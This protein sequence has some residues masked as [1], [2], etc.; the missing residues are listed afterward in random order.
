[1][2]N[3]VRIAGC[4]IL[5]SISVAGLVT[6]C[7][8]GS[9]KASA[10]TTITVEGLPATTKPGPRKAFLADV[11]AFE[12]ANPT[13]VVKPTD[14]AWDSQTFAAKLAGKT[15]ETV[16]RVP[17][18]EPGGLIARKQVANL[19]AALKQWPDYSKIDQKILTV[20][21]DTAGSVYGLPVNQYALGLVYNRAVFTKAGLD[22]NKPPTTWAE[23]QADAKIITDKLKIPG[24]QL[25]SSGGYGGWM[26]TAMTVTHGGQIERQDGSKYVA[27]FMPLR[28]RACLPS[29]T[30]CVGPTR[31]WGPARCSHQPIRCRRWLPASSVCPSTAP[32]N[33]PRS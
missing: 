6:G 18:T 24:F 25:P 32:T 2:T 14:A 1:M 15:A 29:S 20:E 26:L 10:K 19:D 23:V 5:A 12:K 22:P 7:S 27:A 8:S 16:I 33:T 9:S 28:S 17:L 30:R 4:F 21:K 13:I 3:R 31:R 11:A